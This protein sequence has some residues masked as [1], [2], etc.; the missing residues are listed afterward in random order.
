MKQTFR[1][2]ALTAAMVLGMLVGSAGAQTVYTLYTEFVG[3]PPT[4]PNQDFYVNMRMD[5]PTTLMAGYSIQIYYDSSQVILT[6][7][8]DNTVSD[9]PPPLGSDPDIALDNTWDDVVENRDGN[10]AT[11]KVGIVQA[12]D[13]AWWNTPGN[14]GLLHL[15]TAPTYNVATPI[16]LYITDNDWGPFDNCWVNYDLEEFHFNQPGGWT[17][18][19]NLPVSVSMFEIE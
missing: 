7:A 10:P 1:M 4:G 14:C 6:A 13:Y 16:Q 8:T 11:D 17:Y 9:A 3:P 12:A 18:Q 19:Y 2:A 15:T 5:G